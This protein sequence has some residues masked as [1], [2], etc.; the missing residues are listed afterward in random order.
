MSAEGS[1]ASAEALG[2]VPQ[3]I[4][5]GSNSHDSHVLRRF[6]ATAATI[7]CVLIFIVSSAATGNRLGS[8]LAVLLTLSLLVLSR[9]LAFK[10]GSNSLAKSCAIFLGRN[11]SI[12]SDLWGSAY[13][14]VLRQLPISEKFVWPKPLISFTRCLHSTFLSRSNIAIVLTAILI[15]AM[16]PGLFYSPG[17]VDWEQGYLVSAENHYAIV[18]T[19][20]DQIADGMRIFTDLKWSYG[21]ILPCV[22]ALWQKHIFELTFGDYINLVRVSQ[23]LFAGLAAFLYFRYSKG[24]GLA[25]LIVF[26]LVL[27][28]FL[29]SGA[30]IYWPNRTGWRFIGFPLAIMLL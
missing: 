8:Y 1:L 30:H 16:A 11:F 6:L 26:L 7:C 19:Q 27:P 4:P 9:R 2:M 17:F 28:L 23:A 10:L 14:K 5:R 25:G 29:P 15:V 13:S 3:G 12:L 24:N 22:I 21:A 18:V 20:G